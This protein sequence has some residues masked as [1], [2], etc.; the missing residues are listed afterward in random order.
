MSPVL[1]NKPA[2]FN[3]VDLKIRLL[4]FI[5]SVSLLT[6]SSAWRPL[7]HLLLGILGLD[8]MQS[9]EIDYKKSKVEV[10]GGILS[11]FNINYN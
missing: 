7:H 2:W 4:A 1:K 9:K 3:S 5:Y 10:C 11:S 8:D 6:P